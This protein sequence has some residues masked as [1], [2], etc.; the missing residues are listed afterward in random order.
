MI[1]NGKPVALND[2]PRIVSGTSA[3]SGITHSASGNDHVVTATYTG[4]L[5][6]V[7]YTLRGDG[8]MRIDYT[9]NI[10]GN[11][12]NIGV[13]FDYPEDRVT[14]MRWLGGGSQPVWKNR[15]AGAMLDVWEKTA[16]N[17]VPGQSYTFDPIFRGY[18]RDFRWGELKTT[19]ARIRIVS[20]TP[21]LFLRVLTPAN[22]VSP[23]TALFA[24]P[25]GNLSLLHG[26]AAIG[27]KFDDVNS[28]GPMSAPNI[29]QGS[30]SGSFWMNFADIE[31]Q[32]SGVEIVTPYRVRVDF[33]QPMSTAAL[34][35][36]N[37]SISGLV[38]H[39]VASAGGNSVLLDVQPLQPDTPYTLDI[40]AIL[41]ATGEALAGERQFPLLYQPRLE[42][43]L[44]FD[45]LTGGITPDVSGQNRH[46]TVSNAILVSGRR[47]DGLQL[48]GASTSRATVSLPGMAAFTVGAWVKLAS[49][50]PSTFPRLIS[51]ANENVQVFF[52]YSGG[53]T[54]GLNVKGRGD[55]RTSVNVLPAFNTWFHVAVAY[56]STA[57]APSFYLNGQLL[58]IGSIASSTG[59]YGTSGDAVIGNRASDGL[60]GLNGIVDDFRIHSRA[61]TA[62]EI[63]ASVATPQT[64]SFANWIA[65]EGYPG[66]GVNGDAN[67]NGVPDLLDYLSSGTTSEPLQLSRLPDG[68]W[69]FHFRI[70][71]FVERVQWR[72]ETIADLSAGSWTPVSSSD[73]HPW[74]DLGEEI[75]YVATPPETNETKL[76][77]RLVA[78]QE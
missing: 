21:D 73:I 70:G 10:T 7:T 3:L 66:G 37:Y 60:R 33:T 35:P 40:A 51:M 63:A 19:E 13:T 14:S 23:Q 12:S 74:R 36:T 42:L 61:M 68:Q 9:L 8:W 15:L 76:F 57:S 34:N 49:A 6:S 26:I 27:N 48:N 64:E 77:G 30:Y 41:S 29:G 32:V 39:G 69:S 18:H 71:K 46:A 2:G 45:E 1:A 53:N 31:P 24:M 25:P 58:G 52:D 56:D 67:G 47:E 11:Q 5:N 59:T 4:N 72:V 17:P 62:A 38:I 54:I 78:T 75:E 44:P 43:D 16:N 20:E 50:G 22:G 65:S 28:I 55:W